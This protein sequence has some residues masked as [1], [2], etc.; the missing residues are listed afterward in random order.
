VF[1]F[2]CCE[3]LDLD[4]SDF[5]VPSKSPRVSL[6]SHDL[7]RTTSASIQP[8]GVARSVPVDDHTPLLKPEDVHPI[9]AVRLPVS[10]RCRLTLP[11]GAP[12][13]SAA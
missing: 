7:R 11:R 10:H 3:V 1:S 5:P 12:D 13:D 8:W 2:V 9:D 6:E 4:G